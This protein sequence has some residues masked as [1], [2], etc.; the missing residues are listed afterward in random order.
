[1]A[2]H[3]LVTLPMIAQEEGAAPATDPGAGTEPTD[4]TPGLQGAEQKFGI[5]TIFSAIKK[6]L[7]ALKDKLNYHSANYPQTDAN[8]FHEL[9]DNIKS[10]YPAI[11]GILNDQGGGKHAIVVDGY[12]S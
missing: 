10:G 2:N 7:S 11:I 8:R 1:M 3:R 6:R 12:N 9:Q 4:A 5:K